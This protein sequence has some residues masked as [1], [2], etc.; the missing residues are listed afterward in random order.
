MA[1]PGRSLRSAA[2]VAAGLAAVAVAA[3][4]A[5]VAQTSVAA[6]F[7]DD[8]DALVGF[9]VYW[10]D[11]PSSAGR[12]R[13]LFD[14]HNEH[15]LAVPR[16]AALGIHGLAGHLDFTALNLA[17]NLLPLLLLGAL[18]SEFRRDAP[19][20]ERAVGFLPAVLFVV[21]PQAWT[22]VISPTVSLSNNGVMAFAALCFAC[23]ARGQVTAAVLAGGAATFSQGNG[24]FVPLLATGIPWL[25]GKPT[26]A[27][28]WGA[29][30]ALAALA[31]FWA[32]PGDYAMASPWAA[33]ARP[34][35]WAPSALYA[36]YFVGS[37]GGF[38]HPGLS[39][40][41]GAAL[42][43]SLGWLTLRGL[44]RRSPALFTLALFL[45]ASIAG[46]AL[47]RAHQ[48]AEAALLQPRYRLYGS[49]L[50]AIAWLGWLELSPRLRTRRGA[51][52]GAVVALVF[53]VASFRVGVPAA[54]A[55]ASELRAG[56][57]LW[58]ETGTRGLEHPDSRKARFF[59]TRALDA[60]LLRFP[61]DWP[62]RYGAPP[63]AAGKPPGPGAAITWK[64][65]AVHDT[66]GH[67]LVIGEA[68]VSGNALGQRVDIALVRDGT[69]WFAPARSVAHPEANTRRR[70][71]EAGFHALVET[72]SLP[73]G[74]YRLGIRVHQGE[75]D[76]FALGETEVGIGGHP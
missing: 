25:G 55:S 26:L 42:L 76:Y 29:A 70:T 11:A 68:H 64:A 2:W 46:N 65:T 20:A 15:L 74:R 28:N 10:Q 75:H 52:V 38:G 73:A 33:L 54:Q 9:L 43:A 27:R 31:Y 49:A 7:L 22:A 66:A 6:P 60:G 69:V 19:T 23:L 71:A 18:W 50:L 41:V 3:Q 67:L 13:Q 24:I 35:E 63:R 44:P 56:L 21:Q 57:D 48:G 45:L 37:A 39:A 30:A 17:G 59:L 16:L 40:V 4:L 53:C 61:A 12:L 62:G 1:T 32:A 72:G 51:A 47:V 14:P 58:W 34:A 5:L 8:W 36:L